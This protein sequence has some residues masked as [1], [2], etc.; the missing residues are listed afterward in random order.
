MIE[1]KDLQKNHLQNIN[2]LLEKKFNSFLSKKKIWT[3]LGTQ[4]WPEKFPIASTGK[5]QSPIDINTTNCLIKKDSGDGNPLKISYPQIFSGL[6]IQNTGYCWKVDIPDQLAEK[7]CEL[8][9]LLEIFFIEYNWR[10]LNVLI[11]MLLLWI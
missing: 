10:K 1:L 9:F 4:I 7:T 2:L 5:R 3:F 11:V 8:L 6:T